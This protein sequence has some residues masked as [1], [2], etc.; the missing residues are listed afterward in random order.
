MSPGYVTEKIPD[1]I[2]SGSIPITWCDPEGLRQDFNPG[3][4]V[5]LYGLSR[6][7]ARKMLGK[8]VDSVDARTAIQDVPLL[9]TIPDTH[10]V[11]EFVC[12]AVLPRRR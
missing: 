7:Q 11:E 12:K 6:F 2:M 4:V 1:A 9:D 10:E 8:L 5:N 3:A